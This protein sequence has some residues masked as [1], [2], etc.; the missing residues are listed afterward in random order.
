MG[1]E[2]TDH[3]DHAELDQAYALIDQYKALVFVLQN[4]LDSHD[5]HV[6]DPE[7]L[8]PLGSD[9]HQIA[10]NYEVSVK[11]PCTD[12]GTVKHV[13]SVKCLDC[14]NKSIICNLCENNWQYERCD[15]CC[16]DY[17]RCPKD[18][19]VF[20][21]EEDSMGYQCAD[22][23]EYVW[24]CKHC[25][26]TGESKKICVVCGANVKVC[27]SCFHQSEGLCVTCQ[28]SLG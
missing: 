6:C 4:E 11:F 16:D 8:K 24:Y 7:N 2:S 17:W 1:G 10:Y 26:K 22:C 12:C 14:K 13:E 5:K 18:S 20:P 3:T 15:A 28:R 21:F 19:M 23:Q 9:S 27:M 25:I